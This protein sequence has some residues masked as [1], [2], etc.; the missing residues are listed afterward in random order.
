[1]TTPP[2]L[3]LEI[4]A[5]LPIAPLVRTLAQGGYCL[6]NQSNGTL[7]IHKLP[8]ATVLQFKPVT[9]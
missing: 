3:L 5:D 1:M 4:D 2:R 8:V 7:L 9:A 6:S